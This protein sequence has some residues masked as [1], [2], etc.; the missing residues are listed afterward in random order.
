MAQLSVTLPTWRAPCPTDK[1]LSPQ[2]C[3]THLQVQ[4][5]TSAPDLL[6]NIS[7]VPMIP[8]SVNLLTDKTIPCFSDSQSLGKLFAFVYLLLKDHILEEPGVISV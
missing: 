8:P 1:G 7:E 3:S 6:M 2:A 4:A 5:L